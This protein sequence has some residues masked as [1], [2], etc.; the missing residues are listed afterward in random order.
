MKEY[1]WY[2][3]DADGT[4][5][6]TTQLICACFKNTARVT[7]NREPSDEQI[8]PGIGLTLRDQMSVHFG[9][10]SDEEYARLR[11]IHMEYQ[12]SIYKDYLRAFDGVAETLACLNARGKH[13]AVVTSRMMPSAEI[14]LEHTGI[15]SYFE[16]L[17]TPERTSKHKPFP[18]P[19]LKAIELFGAV[20]KETLFVGDAVFDIEC[21]SRAGTDTAF[22]TWSRNRIDSLSTKPT[23]V[24]NTMNELCPARLGE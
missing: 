24:I 8:L 1:T 2:L 11:T 13:C 9:E 5:F 14:Y 4:L 18:E 3:F 15:S 21:G 7:E 23:W 12:R 20:P 6:D 10:L 16:Y 19:A 22:I 17:I